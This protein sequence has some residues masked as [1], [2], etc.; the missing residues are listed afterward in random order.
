MNG[1]RKSAEAFSFAGTV[2][3]S[4]I[5]RRRL[6]PPVY[7]PTYTYDRRQNPDILG[8]AEESQSKLGVP[9]GG[10]WLSNVPDSKPLVQGSMLWAG[11]IVVTRSTMPATRVRGWASAFFVQY[12]S[13]GR[14]PILAA[15]GGTDVSHHAASGSRPGVV[16]RSA[17]VARPTCA[18]TA[19]VDR[20]IAKTRPTDA[21]PV[22]RAAPDPFLGLG[23]PYLT[24]ISIPRLNP[25]PWTSTRL[26]MLS[27]PR[28]CSRLMW[29]VS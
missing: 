15:R 23:M 5:E 28:R 3:F 29:P 8:L 22:A 11:T 18:T 19:T 27:R 21:K 10:T 24:R 12:S 6:L 16:N 9:A 14:G 25:A 26:A 4:V 13:Q 20:Q 1:L 17:N 2:T 7:T